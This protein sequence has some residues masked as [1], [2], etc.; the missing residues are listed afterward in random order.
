MTRLIAQ[1]S[2]GPRRAPS[3][4]LRKLT[5]CSGSLKVSR[6]VSR[7]A[8]KVLVSWPRLDLCDVPFIAP[9]RSP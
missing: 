3:L 4:L 2:L 6:V 1:P 7:L 9:P 8:A 5:S